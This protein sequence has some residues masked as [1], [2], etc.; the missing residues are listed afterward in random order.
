MMRAGKNMRAH[1]AA[2]F[3]KVFI[4]LRLRMIVALVGGVSSRFSSA[5]GILRAPSAI[6]SSSD[7]SLAASGFRAAIILPLM[8]ATRL[9]I[10]ACAEVL[11]QCA[12]CTSSRACSSFFESS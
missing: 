7:R 5:N 10:S 3:E 12:A 11:A 1:R 6:A 4:S 9:P 2:R 8:E